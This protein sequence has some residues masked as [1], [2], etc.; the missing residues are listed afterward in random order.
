GP[1]PPAPPPVDWGSSA[2]E[3]L[4]PPS[5]GGSSSSPRRSRPARLVGP[6][7]AP[8][9]YTRRRFLGRH[10]LWGTGVTSWI[11]ATSRPVAAS[12]RMAVSRPEPGPFTNT[13]TFCSPCSWAFRA[14]ASAASWAANGVD[15]REPLNPT[16][17]ALA[18]ERVLP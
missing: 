14:A 2:G 18:H 15:F 10:P 12:E 5:G 6:V 16:L 3:P 7:F 9:R 13:S 1:R 4:T 17:P 8:Q 11:P